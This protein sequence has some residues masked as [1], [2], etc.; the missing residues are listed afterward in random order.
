MHYCAIKG[1]YQLFEYFVNLGSDINQRKSN[2]QNC[3]LLAAE[4]GYMD[5][6]KR[7]TKE[8]KFDIHI[9]DNCGKSALH[10]CAVKGTYQLFEYFVSLGSDINQR[11]SN[12]QNC[13]LLAAEGGY[14]DLCKRLIK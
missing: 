7:L 10:Y 8:Y 1:N 11:I 3:L 6:C 2:G 9:T 13:L 4:G 14:M 12:G 5:L